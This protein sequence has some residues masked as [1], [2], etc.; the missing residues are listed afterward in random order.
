MNTLYKQLKCF[1]KFFKCLFEFIKYFYIVWIFIFEYGRNNGIEGV[2]HL[3]FGILSSLS[4][5]RIYN[6][7]T[8]M[9]L[10]QVQTNKTKLFQKQV[11]NKTE[12]YIIIWAR[13]QS[14][15]NIFLLSNIYTRMTTFISSQVKKNTNANYHCH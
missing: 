6:S 13:H 3:S 7:S 4:K 8:L 1:F 15:L 2:I 10:V 9:Y 5:L 14:N 11:S 12:E